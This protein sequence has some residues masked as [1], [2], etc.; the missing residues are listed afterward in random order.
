MSKGLEVQ[1]PSFQSLTV[2]AAISTRYATHAVR[3]PMTAAAIHPDDASK[4]AIALPL[5]FFLL[6]ISRRR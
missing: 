2:A 1:W 5:R 6:W 4:S 3:A